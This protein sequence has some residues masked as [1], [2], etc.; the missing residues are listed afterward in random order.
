MS[1]ISQADASMTAAPPPKRRRSWRRRTGIAAGMIAGLALGYLIVTPTGRYLIRAGWEEALI[2]RGRRPIVEVVNDTTLPPLTARKLR[3][4]LAARAFA[5]DSVGL[6]AGESFTTFTQ[7]RSDT[8]VLVL[9]GAYPD[10]LRSRTWWF[11]VVGRVPYKGYFDVDQARRAAEQLRRDGFDA[12]LRPASAFSTLGWFND[13]LV[14]TTLRADSIDLVNTVIHEITHNTYYAPGG[15]TFNESFANFVGARGSAWFFRMRGSPG[16]AAEADARWQ[17]D[18]LMA[19]FW[20]RLY[21]SVDSAFK[22]HPDDRSARIAVRDTIYRA[23]RETLV[24]ELGPKFRVI[25]PRALERLRIDNSAVLAHR[26]YLTDVDL[27][28]QVWLRERRNLRA[29][30]ERII[31]LAR[32][33]KDKRPFDALRRYLGI[34][35]P[36][37]TA[38][39]R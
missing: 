32:E 39:S 6:R 3:L 27:F 22:A 36:M 9:S 24:H 10:L 25:G 20:A 26:V 33:D 35:V 16:A 15:A 2:L 31:K 13:P 12:Y 37:D 18:K 5:A 21:K 4:V 8:L 30:V 34:L 38:S 11:P 28:D 29:T 19:V 7:L 17:D 1:E 14:S 23:A